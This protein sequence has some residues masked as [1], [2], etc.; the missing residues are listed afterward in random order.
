MSHDRY[1]WRSSLRFSPWIRELIKLL[2]QCHYQ[3]VRQP[4]GR[5]T[6]FWFTAGHSSTNG[7]R[8]STLS[9][10]WRTGN[11]YVVDLRQKG[12]IVF[13]S[14]RKK[15]H[16]SGSCPRNLR[17]FEVMCFKK[18]YNIIMAGFVSVYEFVSRE[19]SDSALYMFDSFVPQFY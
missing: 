5:E 18:I 7:K 14:T 19:T 12:G 10:E 15:V 3:A 9:S 11:A 8:V 17:W 2:V 13:T 4:A 6:A 16:S 1:C